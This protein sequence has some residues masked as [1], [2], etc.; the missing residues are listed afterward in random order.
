MKYYIPTSVLAGLGTQ[1]SVKL[2]VQ[3]L[4][5]LSQVTPEPRAMRKD[6]CRYGYLGK[7]FAICYGFASYS[8][9]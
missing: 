3:V 5:S 6:S 9:A 4:I 7:C 2:A 8:I 1:F